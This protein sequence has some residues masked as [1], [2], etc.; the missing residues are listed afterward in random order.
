MAAA[1]AVGSLFFPGTFSQTVG[2]IESVLI[3][4]SVDSVDNPPELFLWLIFSSGPHF[5][6]LKQNPGL[7][8]PLSLS[9]VFPLVRSSQQ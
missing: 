1:D 5:V 2:A 4:A 7:I 9:S 3:S 8:S 6:E